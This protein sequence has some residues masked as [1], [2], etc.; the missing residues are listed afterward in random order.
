MDKLLQLVAG[1]VLKKLGA[2]VV[3]KLL[4]G[5]LSRRG[6]VTLD[7]L[8]LIKDLNDGKIGTETKKPKKG[9]SKEVREAQKR[10]EANDYGRTAGEV[11][12]QDLLLPLGSAATKTA[13][14]GYALYQQILPLV[15]AT[16][17]EQQQRKTSDFWNQALSA[18]LNPLATGAA[19]AAGVN[20]MKGKTAQFAADQVGGLLDNLAQ[21]MREQSERRGDRQYLADTSRVGISEG[22]PAT[23]YEATKKVVGK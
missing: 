8:N 18:E 11:A 14:L 12:V 21:N 22:L 9:V 10:L 3:E 19:Y 4:Q 16:A 6:D 13:G 20:N 15:L 23:S 1:K 2:D 5:T 17:A 7:T